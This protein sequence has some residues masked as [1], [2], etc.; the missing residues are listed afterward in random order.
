MQLQTGDGLV[1][2]R[3]SI[4]STEWAEAQSAAGKQL[5]HT[6]YQGQPHAMCFPS[7]LF[8][9][10]AEDHGIGTKCFMDVLDKIRGN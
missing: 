6:G 10:Q 7:G 2:L 5:I 4:R 8:G 1:A 9:P 3:S